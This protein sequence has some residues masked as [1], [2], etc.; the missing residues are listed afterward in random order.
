MLLLFGTLVT[1][2]QGWLNFY[3]WFLLY[4]IGV[5]SEVRLIEKSFSF[6]IPHKS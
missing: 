2:L 3:A 5:G 6:N 4:G 1:T